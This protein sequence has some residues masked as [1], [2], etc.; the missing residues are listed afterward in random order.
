[1]GPH[2]IKDAASISLAVCLGS[3]SLAAAENNLADWLD[4]RRLP[5]QSAARYIVETAPPLGDYQFLPTI[6]ASHLADSPSCTVSLVVVVEGGR[7]HRPLLCPVPSETTHILAYWGESLVAS[8]L[9]PIS[10]LVHFLFILPTTTS[11][12]GSC[13]SE[14]LKKCGQWKKSSDK[15]VAA[16]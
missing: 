12:T 3:R 8:L 13:N 5:I 1:M 4:G 2:L 6:L 16:I 11:P 9:L 7:H 10:L 14:N 15:L